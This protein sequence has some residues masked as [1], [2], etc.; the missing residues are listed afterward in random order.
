MFCPNCGSKVEDEARFCGECGCRLPETETENNE[1]MGQ[2]KPFPDNIPD[3]AG[4]PETKAKAGNG[5]GAGGFAGI[6]IGVIVIIGCIVLGLG[7]TGKLGKVMGKFG[8]KETESEN[9]PIAKSGTGQK[10]VSSYGELES[11]D[12]TR[13]T[14]GPGAAP[15]ATASDTAGPDEPD[16]GAEEMASDIAEPDAGQEEMASEMA[17]PEAT[18]MGGQE[19]D[20]AIMELAGYY[21]RDKGPSS[22]ISILYADETGIE[23]SAGIGNSG[24]LAYRD[25]RD[26]F[27]EWVN[28]REAVFEDGYGRSIALH[29][30]GDGTISVE[31]KGVD[32]NVDL[33]LTGLYGSFENVDVS[34]A[35]FVLKNSDSQIVSED[36]IEAL[37]P[38]ER[39]IAR[40]EIYARHGRIFK[41]EQL[42]NYFESCSWYEGTISADDFDIDMLN[43]SEKEN[44]NM[45]LAYEEKMKSE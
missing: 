9:E 7:M 3:N 35:E 12:N 15:E 16:A 36:E 17:G 20:D 33:S 32:T 25:L 14:Q 29:F 4:M 34:D 21:A 2:G 6:A 27:A 39:K 5:R 26:C 30:N 41:D 38:I 22:G 24:Y 1:V 19:P 13:R 28:D 11:A 18:G 23:F 40:N 45:I 37:T 44:A 43:S 8:W 10:D 31:E 42:Q